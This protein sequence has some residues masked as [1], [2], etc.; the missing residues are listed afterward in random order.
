MSSRNVYLSPQERKQALVLH[1]ALQQVQ[2]LFDEGE[3][4]VSKLREAGKRIFQDEPQAQ[5]DYVE[6]VHPESLKH[7]ESLSEGALVA[8][9]AKIGT[10]RLIDN[11]VLP[12]TK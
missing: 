5:V 9:A 8:V 12:A 4:S 2:S 10:T 6:I 3:R 7:I 1:R 11:I